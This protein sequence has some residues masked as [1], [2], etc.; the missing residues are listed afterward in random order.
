[1]SGGV[2]HVAH[3]KDILRALY[4]AAETGDAE[5]AY[6]AFAAGADARE[7][8]RESEGF[9]EAGRLADPFETNDPRQLLH[10]IEIQRNG[11]EFLMREIMEKNGESTEDVAQRVDFLL[12]QPLG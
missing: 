12:S 7:D 10:V 5:K 6:H 4:E 2:W 9:N 1:M 8:Y 3:S 11:L